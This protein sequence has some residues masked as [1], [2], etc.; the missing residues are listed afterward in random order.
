MAVEKSAGKIP[1][2]LW[3]DGDKFYLN[4]EKTAEFFGVSTR[5]LINWNDQSGG[6]LKKDTGWWDIQA[7]MVWRTDHETSNE[8][9][10][11]KAEADLKEEQAERARRDNEEKAGQLILATEVHTE[12]AR[13][14]I[15]LKTGLLAMGRKAAGQFSDPDVRIEV[16]K[17]ISD[18]VYNL[19]KQYARGG[20]YTPTGRAPKPKRKKKTG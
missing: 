1:R 15:E 6:A 17:I 13:R 20:K 18:E 4:S 16:E 14:I 19:L 9:R 7:I 5:T 11:L 2:W 10:K 12:W 8:A 3:L